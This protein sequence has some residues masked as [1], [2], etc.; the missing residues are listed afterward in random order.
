MMSNDSELE[1]LSDAAFAQLLHDEWTNNSPCFEN[2]PMPLS[3]LLS[4]VPVTIGTAMHQLQ[5][6]RFGLLAAL[7]SGKLARPRRGCGGDVEWTRAELVA[8]IPQRSLR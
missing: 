4:S 8:A 5:V 1:N 6:D 7:R 3:Q 2:G